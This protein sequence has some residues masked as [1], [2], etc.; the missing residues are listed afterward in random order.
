MQRHGVWDTVIDHFGDVWNILDLVVIL[1]QGFYIF[2]EDAHPMVF[3][4]LILMSYLLSL[5]FLRAF[6]T[7]RVFI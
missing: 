6:K 1:L 2:L 3:A 7:T 4:W 5:K